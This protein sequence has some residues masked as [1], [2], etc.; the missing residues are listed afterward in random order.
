MSESGAATSFPLTLDVDTGVDDALAIAF[1]VESGAS[2]VGI[3]TVAGN[4]PIDLATGNTRSVLSWI[5]ADGIPVHRGASR[6]LS[7]SYSGAAHVHGENG[8]GG[9]EIG[10]GLAPES[11]V[12]AVQALLDNAAQFE[13]ELVL[14][15]LGPLTNVAMALSL[16]PALVR[17]VRK[18]VLMGGAYLSEGNVS[19]HAEFNAYTDPHAAAQ[20]MDAD[21]NEIVAIGLDATHQTVIWRDQWEAISDTAEHTAGLVRQVTGRTFTERGMDGCY[22]HDPLAVGVALYPDLIEV[23]RRTVS[24]TVEGDER[25]KTDVIETG[26]VAVAMTVDAWRF[27]EM[28]AECMGLPRRTGAARQGRFE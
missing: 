8:L 22:L 7:A 1:A 15:A 10:E 13:G 12:N 4:V 25:G 5:S 6:P 9:A 28:F 27:E 20:V 23:E 18:L 11:S 26:H 14:V 19:Q 17:Q 16:R 3:S 2:V 24:V 21:W